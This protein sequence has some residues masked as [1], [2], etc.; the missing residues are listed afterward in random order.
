M[1]HS[2]LKKNCK[3]RKSD[4]NQMLQDVKTFFDPCI[5]LEVNEEIGM[6]ELVAFGGGD[7][8]EQHFDDPCLSS[9]KLIIFYLHIEQNQLHTVFVFS[10][11]FAYNFAISQFC[12]K[13][14]YP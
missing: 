6:Y 3:F 12:K 13:Q 10:C 4:I 5:H 2:S 9:N 14:Y 11:V 8:L 1:N 7:I